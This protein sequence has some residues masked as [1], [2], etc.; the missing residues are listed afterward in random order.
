M[1][2]KTGIMGVLALPPIFTQD[3]RVLPHLI[4]FARLFPEQA[5][6]ETRT[7]TTRRSPGLPDDEYAV[8]ESYCPD[9]SCECRRVMLNV[10]GRRRVNRGFLASISFGFDRGGEMAGPFL[11]P[12]NPQ[13]RHAGMLLDLVANQALADPAYSQR[14]ERHYQQVKEAA[15]DE[16]SPAHRALRSLLTPEEQEELALTARA[17]KALGAL[18][19][20]RGAAA[21]QSGRRSRTK[22]PK[23]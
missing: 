22:R 15:V 14:L 10:V 2:R 13:S 1:S 19:W 18:K 17:V 8:T 21:Q 6:A 16:G 3:I 11:D 12:L 20:Q 5:A 23:R 9:P 7:L 4:P